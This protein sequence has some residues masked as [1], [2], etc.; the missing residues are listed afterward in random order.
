MH[1]NNFYFCFAQNCHFFV[2]NI[3]NMN[4]VLIHS[5]IIKLD[6]KNLVCAWCNLKT[7]VSTSIS[8]EV[9]KTII[10]IMW[11]GINFHKILSSH[12]FYKN[13]CQTSMTAAKQYLFDNWPFCMHSFR[14]FQCR[15]RFIMKCFIQYWMSGNINLS[16]L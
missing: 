7:K 1:V 2:H 4:W 13:R 9:H 10:L 11:C 15:I 14:L 12:L 3:I 8:N 5:K 6:I 16:F